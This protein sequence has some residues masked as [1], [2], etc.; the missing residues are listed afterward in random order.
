MITGCGRPQ[1]IGPGIG[2]SERGLEGERELLF[3]M[4][5]HPAS[6]SDLSLLPHPAAL[7][8]Y[9]PHVSLCV[10]CIYPDAAARL[11][12][13]SHCLGAVDSI[14]SK[15]AQCTHHFQRGRQLCSLRALWWLLDENGV[16]GR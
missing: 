2:R 13:T 3:G 12:M 11:R 6:Q 7:L 5:L 8:L 1:M 15:Q 4:C 14:T 10:Y 16:A 9:S